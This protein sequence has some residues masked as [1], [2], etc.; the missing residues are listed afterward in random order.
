MINRYA[1]LRAIR[2]DL[3]YKNGTPG[4]A[5]PDH[6]QLE[7]DIHVLMKNMMS[8]QAVVG[9]FWVIE[10]AED[11][12]YHA[13]VAFWLDGNRTQ[14]IYPWAEKAGEL[15]SK[16]TNR[17]GWHHRCE[18][19]EHYR[20][21]IN[22]PVRYNDPE[23]IANIRQALAYMTKIQ[24]K[25]R[26]LLHGCNEVPERPSTNSIQCQLKKHLDNKRLSSDNRMAIRLL[27]STFL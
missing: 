20:A 3:F 16:I 17:E 12:R 27:A 6:R 15:W 19:K 23:S 21:N 13:H 8:L 14:I 22:I 5:Q 2:I 10:W 26:L 7:R 11:H 9:Y 24:Q 4:F 1:C 18:Y 25:E